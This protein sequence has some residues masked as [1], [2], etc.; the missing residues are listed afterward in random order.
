MPLELNPLIAAST[1]ESEVVV[2]PD[3]EAPRTFYLGSLAGSDVALAMTGVGMVNAE[4]TTRAAFAELGS[5]FR[6]V[7]F[8]GVAGSIHNIG[9]VAIAE[10][11][12]IGGGPDFVPVDAA[13]L[14]TARALESPG[15]VS[16]AQSVPVGDAACLCPA[17]TARR[18]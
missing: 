11:W 17:S 18:R 12:T 3:G 1:I 9:D 14:E 16:L 2:E 4:Q 15:A 6:G 8:S 7:V 5:C 13:M 10:E